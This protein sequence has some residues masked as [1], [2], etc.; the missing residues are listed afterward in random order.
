MKTFL[1]V[2]LF[3]LT[4]DA[5]VGTTIKSGMW[6][7]VFTRGCSYIPASFGLATVSPRSN[8]FF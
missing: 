7:D 4:T 2:F 3:S 6:D 8:Y 5:V 1:G